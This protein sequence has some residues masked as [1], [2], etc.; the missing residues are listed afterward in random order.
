MKLSILLFCLSIA[1][2]AQGQWSIRPQLGL[3]YT[4]NANYEN[5]DPDADLFWWART[6]NSYNTADSHYNIWLNY[7]NY[8]KERQNN[9][10]S[11]R[12]AETMDMKSHFMGDF[13][14]NLALGGQQY[15]EDSPATTEE[16]F[17]HI[18]AESSLTKSWTPR[19]DLEFSLEPLY[20]L[21]YY[22]QLEDR[23]D[24]TVLLNFTADWQFQTIQS[25]G[26][27]AEFGLVFSDQ[28][29]YSKNYLEFGS[30]WR[31]SARPDLTYVLN[32]MSR[33]S[34]FPN[35]TVSETTV[36]STSKGRTRAQSQDGIETQ[37][38]FQIQ[39]SAIKI[40][41]STELRAT[42]SLNTQSSNSGN[43]D[44]SEVQV[45]TSVLVPF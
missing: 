28:S 24:H 3:G 7:R 34:A 44:Y 21:K 35:R 40:I 15:L 17:N 4:N 25:L 5:S 27:F 41:S 23:K 1:S 38:F 36:V 30:D 14:W 22:S 8:T 9:V 33:Y 39:G 20:Q 42:L 13:E 31:I 37:S 32:F 2:L 29:L 26:P 18:Y 10:F 11:Y 16:S 12:L 6:S 45:Q 43:E 19:P